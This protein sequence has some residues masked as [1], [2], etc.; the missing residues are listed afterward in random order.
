MTSNAWS[1]SDPATAVNLFTAWSPLLPI[2]LRDNM[3]DQLILPKLSK[4]ISDWSPSSMRRGGA[5][6]HTIVFPWLEHAGE[7]MDMVLE[8]SK[9]KI[10]S[11]LKG[12]KVAEGVPT[13]MDAWKQ[14]SASSTGP[15]FSP[16]NIPSL[17]PQAFSKSDWDS[18]LLKHVLPQLGTTLR[19]SFSINPRAQDLKPLE[20][21]LAWRPLMRSS[22]MDQ[23]LEGG[24]FVKWLEA[25]YIWLTHEPNFDQVAEW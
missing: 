10:R 22:M 20:D 2:F 3:L 11:W 13:G 16:T 19:D 17:T 18:L 12:W 15:L 23:L 7:R 6:L 25:L 8:E 9:R 21:V 14:V 24:F 4:A 1:P 5:A